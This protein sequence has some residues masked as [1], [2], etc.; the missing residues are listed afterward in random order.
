MESDNVPEHE[1]LSD[2]D[3]GREVPA[4]DAPV[5][6]M[7]H[8]APEAAVELHTT[9]CWI[10]MTRTACLFGISMRSTA[11]LGGHDGPTEYSG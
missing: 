2:T 3:I 4:T 7:M 6:L 1:W 11:S 9:I 5:R 10:F 8:S